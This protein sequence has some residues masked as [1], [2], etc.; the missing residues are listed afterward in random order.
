M[1][2]TALPLV[3]LYVANSYYFNCGM[4]MTDSIELPADEKIIREKLKDI[5][6]EDDNG[7]IVLRSETQ[8]KCSIPR[9]LDILEM[10][11]KLKK[12]S[13]K[14]KDVLILISR[15][16]NFSLMSII[17]Q[18]LNKN[19]EIYENITCE[20]DLGR[21][22]YQDDQLPF[23][24]PTYLVNYIDFKKLGHEACVKDSIRIIPEMK[25]AEKL[26]SAS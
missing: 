9:N 17:N 1:T 3:K 5:E 15:L 7:Y 8:F 4:L 22:L 13:D 12:L 11:K 25:L 24:I 6:A 21:K 14:D 18:V 26:Y 19:Y 16:G 23:K 2:Q 20:E 10:N